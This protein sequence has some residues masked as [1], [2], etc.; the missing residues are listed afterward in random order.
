MW[1]A[2]VFSGN[3]ERLWEGTVGSFFDT[4]L[5]CVVFL[6]AIRMLCICKVLVIHPKP[7]KSPLQH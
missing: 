2:V 1:E 6:A 5:Y 3:F 4:D 7:K